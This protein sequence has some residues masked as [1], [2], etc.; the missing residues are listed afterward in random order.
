MSSSTALM[1]EK[2][3]LLPPDRQQQILEFIDFLAARSTPHTQPKN[4]GLSALDLAGDI[5]GCVQDA[6]A[7]LSTNPIHMEGFGQA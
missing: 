3:E 6:P 4:L 7:D 2:F 1:L 5:V